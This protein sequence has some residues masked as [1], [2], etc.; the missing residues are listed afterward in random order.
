MPSVK[1]SGN[2]QPA[3][4]PALKEAADKAVEQ[5]DDNEG[6]V[7]TVDEPADISYHGHSH[8]E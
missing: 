8:L 6:N 4:D 3:N 5:A 2:K 1:R 7:V